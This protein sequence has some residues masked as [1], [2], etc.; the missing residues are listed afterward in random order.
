MN[1][2]GVY[3]RVYLTPDGEFSVVCMQ[4]FD[5]KD[6]DQSRFVTDAR[7]N[8]EDDAKRWLDGETLRIIKLYRPSVTWTLNQ[9]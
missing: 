5:E 9:P 1:D 3:H 4:D 2:C 8:T 7:F 6:Y